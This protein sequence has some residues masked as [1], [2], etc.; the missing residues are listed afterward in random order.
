MPTATGKATK[1]FEQKGEAI[2][3]AFYRDRCGVSVE[4]TGTWQG[5]QP[6]KPTGPGPETE[7]AIKGS[8]QIRHLR[9]KLDRVWG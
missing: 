9:S 7:V 6:G 8:V 1:E 2:R 4:G 5:A 3:F